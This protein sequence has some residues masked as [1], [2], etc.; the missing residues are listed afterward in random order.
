MNI[1]TNFSTI[2]SFFESLVQEKILQNPIFE[3]AYTG[4]LNATYI[5]DVY[6]YTYVESHEDMLTSIF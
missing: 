5:F 4:F 2:Q 6:Q 1:Q 3:F